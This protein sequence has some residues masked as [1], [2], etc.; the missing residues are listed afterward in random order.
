MRPAQPAGSVGG[1][2]SGRPV[3]SGAIRAALTSS[4]GGTSAPLCHERPLG[5]RTAGAGGG[6]PR[7]NRLLRAARPHRSARSHP[8]SASVGRG[9]LVK[10][11]PLPAAATP[12]RT[13]PRRPCAQP[14]AGSAA[15]A[16]TAPRP[17][18]PRPPQNDYSRGELLFR[19]G[20]PFP[21]VLFSSLQPRKTT[22]GAPVTC[23]GQTH[24]FW[25]RIA[26]K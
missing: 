25:R 17:A 13:A 15:A 18:Q 23:A 19:H 2:D 12:R 3:C 1:G 10:P 16:R 22:R 7:S 20:Q 5:P 24:R 11:W 21:R 9:G 6:G 14:A 8:Q 4:S 26:A